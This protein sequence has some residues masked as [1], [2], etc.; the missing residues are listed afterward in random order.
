MKFKSPDCHE[1][2]NRRFSIFNFCNNEELQIIN[3]R[4]SCHI[5]SKGQIIFH[6]GGKPNGVFSVYSGKIK[7][8]KNNKEG[9]EQIIRLAKPGDTIGYRALVSQSVY[10]ATAIAMDEAVVCFIA[11]ENFYEIVSQNAKVGS[12]LI[13]LL[14]ITLGMAEERMAKMALKP[15]RERLAEALLL[16]DK[17]Y[18]F[19]NEK[20]FSISISREDLASIVGTA[21]ETAI[22]FLSEFKD[23]NIIS[24]KGSVI[25]IIDLDKLSKISQLYD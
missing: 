21:K 17:T 18:N 19:Q 23:E 10:S 1:C 25:K 15:V 16:L 12:E 22:R 6:E 14:S 8:V 24:T 2:L 5:Y 3:E 7:I 4:K 9:K 11:Q 20:G 13:K